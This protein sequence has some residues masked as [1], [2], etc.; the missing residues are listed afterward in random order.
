[1]LA[2]GTGLGIALLT[3][4]GRGS[5]NIP[6]Q[7][8]P[9]EFGHALYSPVADPAKKEEE[10]RLAAYL[11]RTLYS[12]KHAIEYEDIVSGRGVLAVYQWVTAENRGTTPAQ[13]F[14]LSLSL[15]GACVATHH[16]L[17]PTCR[18]CQVR[19]GRGGQRCCLP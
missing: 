18:G 19:V 4:L 7:V 17:A 1:V 16:A 6:L 11:S 3:S 10:E 9:M 8:M 15:S 5:R 12:G 2:V 13:L 14:P